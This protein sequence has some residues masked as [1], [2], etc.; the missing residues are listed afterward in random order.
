MMTTIE[1]E[2]AEQELSESASDVDDGHGSSLPMFVG[3]LAATAAGLL[4]WRLQRR[5]M[6][7]RI[8]NDEIALADRYDRY[9]G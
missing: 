2:A 1:E 5:R 4:L 7:Q 9:A 3:V 8:V 6:K